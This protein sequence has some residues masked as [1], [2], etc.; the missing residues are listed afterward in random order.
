M[1]AL[2]GNAGSILNQ[3]PAA[4]HLAED[5]NVLHQIV[6]SSLNAYD[7]RFQRE[8]PARR[9]PSVISIAARLLPTRRHAC[10]PR[11]R[12]TLYSPGR[13]ANSR[14][15]LSDYDQHRRTGTL[16]LTQAQHLAARVP[17]AL[18]EAAGGVRESVRATVP[19]GSWGELA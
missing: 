13:A 19:M 1:S 5:I 8:E 2:V 16:N 3:T 10:G 11:G 4:T 15:G 17:A 9:V 6:V 7:T 12:R 14:T 18:I